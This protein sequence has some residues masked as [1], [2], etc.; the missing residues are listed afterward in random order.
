MFRR[1]KAA[2][3]H[4]LVELAYGE[5]RTP[6]IQRTVTEQAVRLTK[7]EA[8]QLAEELTELVDGLAQA[9][10]GPRRGRSPRPTT[11]SRSSSRFPTTS[12]ED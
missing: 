5:D 6:G 4:H 2:W 12:S 3:G 10:P 11:S 1:T 8:R 7:A 9:Q